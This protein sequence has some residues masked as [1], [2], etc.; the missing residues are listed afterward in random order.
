MAMVQLQAMA[1]GLPLICTPNTGGED[2]IEEGKEGFIVPVRDVEAIQEKL[3]RLYRDPDLRREMGERAKLKVRS[4]F[5]WDDY[6]SRVTGEY[7]RL[8]GGANNE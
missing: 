7:L 8:L 5:S 6:G 2:L 4:G 1:C 3:L